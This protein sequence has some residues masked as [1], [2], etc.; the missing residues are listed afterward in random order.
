MLVKEQSLRIGKFSKLVEDL[1]IKICTRENR[2]RRDEG[3]RKQ[4]L[5]SL[6]QVVGR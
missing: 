3:A 4:H 5:E 1:M 2:H 6:E